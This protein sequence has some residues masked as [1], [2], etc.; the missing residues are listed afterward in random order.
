[1]KA[2]PHRP[3][4]QGSVEQGNAEFKKALQK[5]IAGNPEEKWPLIGMYVVNAQINIRPTDN[6]ATRSAYEI[7]DSSYSI[8]H[9]LDSELLKIAQTEY[10]LT[11]VEDLM[12]VVGLKDQ[13]A[14]ITLEEV[15]DLIRDADAVYDNDARLCEEATQTKDYDEL[16]KFLAENQL[17]LLEHTYADRVMARV[18]Q[19]RIHV[20]E[21]DWNRSSVNAT[22]GK[23]KIPSRGISM[24]EDSPTRKKTRKAVKDAKEKQAE[25]GNRLR[26]V[27]GIKYSRKDQLEVGDICTVSTQGLRKIYFPHLPVS[28]TGTSMKG[29]VT[30]R[31]VASKYGYL[32]GTFVLR[33]TSHRKKYTASILNLD[34]EVD[35]LK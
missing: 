25:K 23:R 26:R 12:N 8:L 29:E 20:E 27:K 14:L 1:M 18:E 30:K 22:K 33:D 11:S 31:A 17:E 5:W 21:S 10:G 34:L 4:E 9:I 7:S 24:T 28:V 32:R 19:D 15:Q 13:N 16:E 3:N 6:E 2:K 35:G